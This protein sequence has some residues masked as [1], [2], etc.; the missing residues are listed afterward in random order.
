MIGATLTAQS[1]MAVQTVGNVLLQ[2]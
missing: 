2:L 1:A